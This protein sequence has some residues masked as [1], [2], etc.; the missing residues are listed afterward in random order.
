MCSTPEIVE[1]LDRWETSGGIWRVLSNDSD[2]V[3]FGLFTCD[4]GEQM[5][6]VA[7][8]RTQELEAFL[9]GRLSSEDYLT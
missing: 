1:T 8:P 6:Q 9:A 3:V 5:S 2:S 4:G 7:S